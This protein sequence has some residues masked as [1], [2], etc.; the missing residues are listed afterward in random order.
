MNGFGTM[1]KATFQKYQFIFE[2]KKSEKSE[3]ELHFTITLLEFQSCRNID[4]L[5]L[6]LFNKFGL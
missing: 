4:F 6:I 1:A 3:K 2:T 5:K